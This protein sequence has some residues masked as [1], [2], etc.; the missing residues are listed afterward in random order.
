MEKKEKWP[1]LY[2]EWLFKNTHNHKAS[3]AYDG[4]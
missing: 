2:K 1:Y 4:E 3:Q